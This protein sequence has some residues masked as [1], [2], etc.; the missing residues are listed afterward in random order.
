MEITVNTKNNDCMNSVSL[1]EEVR[2]QGLLG[3]AGRWF[4]ELEEEFKNQR[5]EF[6]PLIDFPR[7]I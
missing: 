1:L 4:Q 5:M 3:R 6:D 7:D 2:P